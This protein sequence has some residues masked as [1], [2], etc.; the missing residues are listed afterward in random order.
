MAFVSNLFLQFKTLFS[1]GDKI[2]ICKHNAMDI[3]FDITYK[4]PWS[5]FIYGIHLSL[6]HQTEVENLLVSFMDLF[7]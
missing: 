5:I 3:N 4:I 1:A 6:I 7:P 2:H